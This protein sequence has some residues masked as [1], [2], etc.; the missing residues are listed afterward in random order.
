MDTYRNRPITYRLSWRL[1]S[2][3]A[4]WLI[5]LRGISS[6]LKIYSKFLRLRIS[7]IWVDLRNREMLLVGSW[8]FATSRK[9]A[10]LFWRT[11]SAGIRSITISLVLV[12]FCLSLSER[13]RMA[14][15]SIPTH[16]WP[17][18]FWTNPLTIFVRSQGLESTQETSF[19]LRW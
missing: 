11:L 1:R 3:F 16:N 18:A 13:P 10:V 5:R 6:T 8:E 9:R 4:S 7:R 2:M 12:T 19:L 15:R 17:W 14:L